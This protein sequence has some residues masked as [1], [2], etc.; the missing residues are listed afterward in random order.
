MWRVKAGTAPVPF[1]RAATKASQAERLKEVLA[2]NLRAWR[3][4]RGLTQDAAAELAGLNW[5]HWQKL[6]AG[7]VNVT[8]KTL[9]RI[10]MAADIDIRTLFAQ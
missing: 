10:C 1:S 4:G 8:L 9:E 5:R 2:G 7:T 3:E 6:E